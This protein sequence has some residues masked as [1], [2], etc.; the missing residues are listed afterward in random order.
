[1][2]VFQE[3]DASQR[4]TD[5]DTKPALLQSH[6]NYLGKSHLYDSISSGENNLSSSPMLGKNGK[7]TNSYESR[8]F[9]SAPPSPTGTIRCVFW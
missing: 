4:V 1:M 2:Y 3:F 9:L 6:V 5:V 8:G 7:H